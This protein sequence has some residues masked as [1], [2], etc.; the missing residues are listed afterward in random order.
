MIFL[1]TTGL[2]VLLVLGLCKSGRLCR[3]YSEPHFPTNLEAIALYKT[4]VE[5]LPSLVNETISN[6]TILSVAT[7]VVA[8][9]NYRISIFVNNKSCYEVIVYQTPPCLAAQ[10]GIQSI[11]GVRPVQGFQNLELFVNS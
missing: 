3:G 11:T 7:Q 10:N 5:Q 9:L 8:G 6:L 2:L 1:L 4:L